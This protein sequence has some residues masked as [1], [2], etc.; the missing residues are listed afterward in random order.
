MVFGATQ[1]LVFNIKV[2]LR[3]IVDYKYGGIYIQFKT[4]HGKFE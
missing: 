1:K 4:V 3:I 2:L